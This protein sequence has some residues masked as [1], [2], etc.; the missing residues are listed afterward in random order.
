MAGNYGYG[1]AKQELFELILEKF[2]NE[3]ERYTYLMENKA[4]IDKELL[5]GAEKARKVAKEVLQR[6]RKKLGYL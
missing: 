3:R 6:T 4:E 2:K 1:H 5:K